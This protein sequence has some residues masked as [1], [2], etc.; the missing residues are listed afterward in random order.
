VLF[1]GFSPQKSESLGNLSVLE[2]EFQESERRK[3]IQAFGTPFLDP[4]LM[5]ASVT[6][7]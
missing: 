4:R 1:S 6:D 2:S 5:K 7:L 3:E